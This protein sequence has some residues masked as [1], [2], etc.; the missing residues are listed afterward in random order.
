MA[1][2]ICLH[3]QVSSQTLLPGSP[4]IGQAIVPESGQGGL[5]SSD[6]QATRSLPHSGF[7]PCGLAPWE[8][9]P[10]N[11]QA[12]AGN[13]SPQGTWCSVP[14]QPPAP[15]RVLNPGRA[16]VGAALGADMGEGGGEK[17]RTG[18]APDLSSVP[19]RD[20]LGCRVTYPTPPLK[21]QEGKTELVHFI[22]KSRGQD[23]A[24]AYNL[25]GAFS[26]PG[27]GSTTYGTP[28][29]KYR[30]P[31]DCYWQPQVSPSPP[32]SQGLATPCHY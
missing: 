12:T 20:H 21:H 26:G 8:P 29:L 23:R 4:H 7:H 31:L 25:S 11:T 27:M 10:P 32:N 6:L 5:I 19:R 28:G 9:P 13:A 17:E 24:I 22:D 3:Y 1:S 14:A 2:L 30:F 18:W 15:T 16:E